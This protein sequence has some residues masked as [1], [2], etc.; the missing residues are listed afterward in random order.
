MG[1]KHSSATFISHNRLVTSLKI[2]EFLLLMYRVSQKKGKR[3]VIIMAK[4]H[5]MCCDKRHSCTP[6]KTI[7]CLA[8]IITYIMTFRLP[9]FFVF[10]SRLVFANHGSQVRG[11]QTVATSL[12]FP[13]ALARNGRSPITRRCKHSITSNIKCTQ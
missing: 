3:N 13:L 12:N 8:Y 9:F 5:N 6:I 1:I 11:G 4:R 2:Y 10:P 7:F